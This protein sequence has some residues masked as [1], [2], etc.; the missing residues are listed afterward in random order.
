MKPKD[1]K[2]IIMRRNKIEWGDYKSHLFYHTEI[3]IYYFTQKLIPVC[4]VFYAHIKILLKYT[5]ETCEKTEP[6]VEP[7]QK[8]GRRWVTF[9]KMKS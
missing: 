2:C 8:Y 9:R 1:K 5:L 6:C 4:Y 7:Q 3:L